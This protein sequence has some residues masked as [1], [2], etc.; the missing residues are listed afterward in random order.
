MT[1]TGISQAIRRAETSC[2]ESGGKLTAKRKNVLATLLGA[3]APLSAYE[4]ADRYRETFD[5]A[6]PPMSVYRMLDFLIDE[7]LVHRLASNSKYVA[8]SHIT[9]DH[10]HQTPQFLICDRCQSVREVGVATDTIE[11]LR[12]SVESTG[13]SLASPQLELHGLCGDCKSE[14]GHGGGRPPRRRQSSP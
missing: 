3:G 13:F 14:G 6:I 2:R 9:C 11:A 4:I 7:N 1:R 5:D 8:C 12:E 10:P